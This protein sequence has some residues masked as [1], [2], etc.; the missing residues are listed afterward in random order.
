M[1]KQLYPGP[2][3][4]ACA[5]AI[6]EAKDGYYADRDEPP[7]LRAGWTH[8]GILAVTLARLVLAEAKASEGE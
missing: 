6:M 2:A 1:T 5:K 7:S 3:T 8:P 4:I